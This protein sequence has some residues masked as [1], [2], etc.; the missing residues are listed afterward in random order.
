MEP[1]SSIALHK[2][3][4]EANRGIDLEVGLGRDGNLAEDLL[5]QGEPILS[6]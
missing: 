6:G 4:V 3:E 5:F 2:L 1:R